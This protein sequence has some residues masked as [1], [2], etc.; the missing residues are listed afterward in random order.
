MAELKIK[1]II[2]SDNHTLTDNPLNDFLFV[3]GCSSFLTGGTQLSMKVGG[4]QN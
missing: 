1:I 3:L 2:V 4:T